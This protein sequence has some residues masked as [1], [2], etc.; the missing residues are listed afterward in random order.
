MKELSL[1][2]LDIIQNSIAAGATLITLTIFE[3]I[4]EDILTFTVTDNGCGMPEEM[5]RA[6]TDPF[7]TSRTTRKV[8]LGIPL[9]KMAA[10]QTGGKIRLSSAVGTGTTITANFTYG[11]IDRQ[12]LGNMAETMLGLIT[13]HPDLDFVYQ[14]R[15][16]DAQYTLDTREM[17]KSLGGVPLS[18]SAVT[19]WLSDFLKENEAALWNH[20]I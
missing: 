4:G 7:T 14:H 9:L 6:V 3:S 19:L 12:P 5:V 1:H 20:E 17:R 13:S 2:I 18:E 11:H 8:G 16:E 10:E 15:V